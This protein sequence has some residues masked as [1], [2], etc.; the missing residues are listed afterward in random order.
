MKATIIRFEEIYA[1]CRKEDFGIVD[2]KRINIPI[3]AKEGDIL[4]IK[5]DIITIEKNSDREKDG[6][7]RDII[8]DIW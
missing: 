6:F 4:N 2:I 7:Q 8:V 1:I 5:D 3:E